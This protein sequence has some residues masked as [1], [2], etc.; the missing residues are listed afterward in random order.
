ML[1]AA[2][3]RILAFVISNV[4]VVILGSL[5]AWGVQRASGSMAKARDITQMKHR[6]ELVVAFPLALFGLDAVALVVLA[7]LGDVP[8]V[9]VPIVVAISGWA[10]YWLSPRRRCVTSQASI[11]VEGLPNRVSAFVADVP[12]QVRWIPS[13]VSYTPDLPGP[14]GPRFRA[15]ERMTDGRQIEGVAEMTSD[16]PGVEVVLMADGA[17]LTGD[18]YSFAAEGGGTRVIKR[19]VVELPYMLALAGGMF[20]AGDGGAANQRRVDELQRLKT[21]FE[22]A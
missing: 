4:V 17:G 2:S 13:A 12:G 11:V 20:L 9:I 22:S 8:M 7:A 18:Y 16:V 6:A 10:V 21:A 3:P 1:L 15:V 19:T 5:Y 14:R